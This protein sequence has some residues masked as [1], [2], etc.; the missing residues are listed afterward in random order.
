MPQAAARYT[1]DWSDDFV[2]SVLSALF[3]VRLKVY[4]DAIYRFEGNGLLGDIFD[5][6]ND[7]TLQPDDRNRVLNQYLGNVSI[8]QLNEDHVKIV[9]S[10][11]KG[12]NRR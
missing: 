4:S 9:V 7:S 11:L 5:A 12:K 8:D 3:R 10:G 2:F 6:Y 1:W